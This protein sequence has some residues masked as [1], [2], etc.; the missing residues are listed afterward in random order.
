M[1]GFPELDTTYS[2]TGFVKSIMFMMAGLMSGAALSEIR[3][4][5]SLKTF[6]Q[7]HWLLSPGLLMW[8]MSDSATTLGKAMFVMPHMFTAWSTALL[9]GG[10]SKS[11]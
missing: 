6:V 2:S 1:I 8:Q 10:K 4:E 7:Y 3:G 9:M 5:M 11:K